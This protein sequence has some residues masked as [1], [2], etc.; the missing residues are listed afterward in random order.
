MCC[1]PPL[2][3]TAPPNLEGGTHPTPPH[4]CQP[5]G[6][7]HPGAP[8]PPHGVLTLLE[9]PS[10]LPARYGHR[11]R[12]PLP[13]SGG[14]GGS[15]PDPAQPGRLSLRGLGCLFGHWCAVGRRWGSPPRWPPHPCCGDESTALSAPK[16]PSGTPRPGAEIGLRVPRHG[17]PRGFQGTGFFWGWGEGWRGRAEAAFAAQGEE[18]CLEQWGN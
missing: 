16:E 15:M 12:A 8:I 6:P 9:V 14:W 10:L 17:E 5:V 1:S 13:I 2:S 11:R 18:L 3:P 7:R 4:H